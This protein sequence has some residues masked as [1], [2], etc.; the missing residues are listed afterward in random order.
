MA[1]AVSTVENPILEK[2]G[3]PIKTG[4]I[5]LSQG[6]YVVAMGRVEKAIPT[7]LVA[8]ADL[9]K[10]VGQ[11]VSVAVA[12]GA[13]VVVVPK[14]PWWPRCF[15]CYIPGPD[16]WQKINPELQRTLVMKYVNQ[17]VLTEAQG[18]VLQQGMRQG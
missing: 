15:L 7:G 13:L 9:K 3:L 6:R 11:E 10:L 16:V 8:E 1:K 2:L 18:Q 14:K 4:K 12:K 17:G 5:K